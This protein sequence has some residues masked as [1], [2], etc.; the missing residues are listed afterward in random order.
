[1][2]VTSEGLSIHHLTVAIR[3]GLSSRDCVLNLRRMANARQKPDEANTTLPLEHLALT[4]LVS[5]WAFET[6]ANPSDPGRS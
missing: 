4:E 5:A 1:M 3:P 6:L 2:P